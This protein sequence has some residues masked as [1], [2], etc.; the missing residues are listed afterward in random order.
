[1]I[2]KRSPDARLSAPELPVE[3]MSL[4]AGRITSE[5]FYLCAIFPQLGKFSELEVVSVEPE[6]LS[7]DVLDVAALAQDHDSRRC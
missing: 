6:R 3:V 4:L 5:H 1:M 2:G 7:I